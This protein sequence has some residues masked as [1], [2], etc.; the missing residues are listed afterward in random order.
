MITCSVVL[1]MPNYYVKVVPTANV[2]LQVPRAVVVPEHDHPT[3][4]RGW[5]MRRL[6]WL[7]ITQA[8]KG[9]W[10]KVC[11]GL[12]R[13]ALIRYMWMLS[14]WFHSNVRTDRAP[15]LLKEISMCPTNISSRNDIVLF[16]LSLTSI[17]FWIQHFQNWIILQ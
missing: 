7:G 6:Y 16:L 11:S 13:V 14:A 1:D 4:D 8:Q 9:V 3:G 10:L 17:N 15:L 2:V 12:F 5:G